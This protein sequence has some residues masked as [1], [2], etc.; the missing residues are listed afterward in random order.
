MR[1]EELVEAFYRNIVPT[2]EQ[3]EG[4]VSVTSLSFPCLR[5]AVLEILSRQKVFQPRGLIYTWV[6]TMCHKTS[7]LNGE[8][9]IPLTWEGIYGRP[10]EYKD[11]VLLEKKT[12]R[13]VPDEP[14]SHHVRQVR[15]YAVLL[16]KNGRPVTEAWILYINVDSGHIQPFQVELSDLR[17]VEEEMLQR[18]SKVLRAAE[19]GILPPREMVP[20]EEGGRTLV[21][22]YCKLFWLCMANETVYIPTVGLEEAE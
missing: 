17:V 3:P 8:T 2:Y 21:C 20:W 14:R 18:K 16:G 6:G 15:Y 4:T 12:T 7:I 22:E 11:G 1:A 19:A 5:R 13:S 10:D 9:E